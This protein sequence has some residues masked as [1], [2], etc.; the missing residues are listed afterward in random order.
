LNLLHT[1]P[2]EEEKAK[3]DKMTRLGTTH[4]TLLVV[5]ICLASITFLVPEDIAPVAMLVIG[6]LILLVGASTFKLQ[7]FQKCPRCQAR[8]VRGRTSCGQCGLEYNVSPSKERDDIEA[9][10]RVTK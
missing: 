3:L 1:S 7:Y 2:T 6:C 5:L 4:Y 10:D 8:I 9:D